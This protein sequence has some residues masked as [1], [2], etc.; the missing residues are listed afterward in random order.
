MNNTDENRAPCRLFHAQVFPHNRFVHT[1]R[2]ERDERTIN[3]NKAKHI[4]LPVRKNFKAHLSCYISKA[5]H[6]MFRSLRMIPI[7]EADGS[8]MQA[9]NFILT[10]E[11]LLREQ[12]I[13]AYLLTGEGNSKLMEG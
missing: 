3:S 7:M 5:E 11:L 8:V 6:S 13:K 2:V 12:I 4:K 9:M 1:S 10:A